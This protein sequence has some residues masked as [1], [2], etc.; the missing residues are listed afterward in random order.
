M[1]SQWTVGDHKIQPIH[2][3]NTIINIIDFVNVHTWWIYKVK[4]LCEG[5]KKWV[6]LLSLFKGTSNN[7]CSLLW[8]C[9]SATIRILKCLGRL[10]TYCRSCTGVSPPK[11]QLPAHSKWA[12]STCCPKC[13]HSKSCRYNGIPECKSI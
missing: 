9:K 11:M 10:L 13:E 2:A 3:T 8:I 12:L 6:D 5:N 4:F 7:L 1:F